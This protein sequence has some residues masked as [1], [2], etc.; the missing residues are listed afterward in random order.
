[1]QLSEDFLA[2]KTG[3]DPEYY[4]AEALASALHRPFIFISTLDWHKSKP[5]FHMNKES[6]KPTLIFGIYMRGS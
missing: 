6:D 3:L 2:G 1:M 4:L 5:I